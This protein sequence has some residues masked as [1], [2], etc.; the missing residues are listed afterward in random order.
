MRQMIEQLETRKL[1]STITY[2][3]PAG[4]APGD[5]D[6]VADAGGEDFTF[7]FSSG[8]LSL[9]DGSGTSGPYYVGGG[10]VSFTGSDNADSALFQ[11][12]GANPDKPASVAANF[13]G[14]DDALVSY[15][16]DE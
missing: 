10:D 13:K 6:V 16:F 5:I 11:T 15:G 14:G 8:G 7:T 3:P 2:T 4:G 12:S 9:T 1:F